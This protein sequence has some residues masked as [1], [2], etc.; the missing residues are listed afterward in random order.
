MESAESFGIVLLA[1]GSSSRMG[2][3]KQLL[4]VDGEP[5]LV[6]SVR[7]ALASKAQPVLVVLG[8]REKLHRKTLK[9]LEVSVVADPFWERG[10][11]HSLK[12][13]VSEILKM[14]PH[15]E[16]ILVMVCDQ[17]LLTALHLKELSEKKIKEKALI[18]ASG[19]AGTKGVPAI[20]DRLI[21][22]AL[23]QLGDREGAKKM[24]SE[25]SIPVVDFPGG[26]TDLDT[27]EDYRLF[28]E[29]RTRTH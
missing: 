8:S 26:A 13:G 22:S 6:R 14:A 19:Y 1:A 28:I 5:L 17:P 2:R 3:S 15:L 27:P 23:L 7:A 29:S 11:G 4:D 18:V 16:A 12:T 21:F 9:N 10:I 20:F 24:L 25:N